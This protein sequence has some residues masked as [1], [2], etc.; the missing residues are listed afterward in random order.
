VHGSILLVFVILLGARLLGIISVYF[1]EE[2]EVSLAV[3][4]AALVADTAGSLYR[5]TVQLGYY[6]LIEFLDLILGSRIDLIPAIMK[7]LSAVA[8]ALIP[9]LGFFAFKTDLTLRERWLVVFA[10]AINP[11][12]WRSSQ[13]GNTAMIATAVATVALVILSNRPA[14][15]A[16]VAALA[17][18]G[19]AILVRAD[20]V[21]LAPL[22]LAL[23]CRIDGS[24]VRALKWGTGLGLAMIAVYVWIHLVDPR[25]DSAIESVSQHMSIGVPTMFWEYLLWAMSPIPI[26]F[27][28][29]GMRSLLDSRP[30]LLGLLLCWCLPTLLFYFRATT[31]VRYFVNA[32]VPLSVAA[33]V[34]MAELVTQLQMRMRASVAWTATVGFAAVHL[35]LA[36]GHFRADRPIEMLYSGTFGTDDGPMPTGALLIRTYLTPGSLLR[37]LPHPQFGR[38][39]YPFWEG[40]SFRKAISILSDPAAPRRTIIVILTGGFGHAFHYHT[41]LA[42]AR[43]I[44]APPRGELLWEG[45]L[46]LELGPSRVMTISEWSEEYHRPARF[47][48]KA[49]D[50][51]WTLDT[52]PL[53]RAPALAKMPVG[54][55]LAPIPSFD[56]HFQTFQVVGR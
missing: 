47:A 56:E 16:Q 41:H 17:L 30:Q 42:G 23:L 54:L 15:V 39:S 2:D 55:R 38:Q 52:N 22:V 35:F 20:S 25:A 7:G 27:A 18:F 49:G 1:L 45:Q 51:V 31:T 43:F 44:S 29:W 26:T 24:C 10:L 4:A 34:G 6:R 13:Y 19:A 8:G 28:I 36:L 46:W 53:A 11:I 14:R 50:Q 33:G 5:Y 9:T 40:P 12:L 21:L 3:G 48:V 37:S 32:A